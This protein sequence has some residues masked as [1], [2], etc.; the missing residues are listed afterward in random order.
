M[1]DAQNAIFFRKRYEFPRAHFLQYSDTVQIKDGDVSVAFVQVRNPLSPATKQCCFAFTS[2]SKPAALL[3]YAIPFLMSKMFEPQTTKVPVPI[4]DFPPEAG[5][6]VL[7]VEER[8]NARAIALA[9]SLRWRCNAHGTAQVFQD[10]E[11]APFEWSL[12]GKR[13]FPVCGKFSIEPL[14]WHFEYLDFIVDPEEGE[15]ESLPA[16]PLA[17][18][19]LME[20]QQL[21]HDNPRSALVIAVAAAEVGTK[22]CLKFIDSGLADI[23][24]ARNS[25]PIVDLLDRYYPKD[26]R[27]GIVPTILEQL[28]KAVLDR[29]NLVHAGKFTLRRDQLRRRLRAIEDLLRILDIQMGFEWAEKFISEKTRAEMG[30]PKLDLP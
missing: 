17:F 26:S 24:D 13:W 27:M 7:A 9:K 14:E 19:L 29:N 11:I 5:R 28:R 23:L 6:A 16:E 30:L 2:V 20:A 1:A 3:T 21:Q 8:L 4:K 15:Y 18:E 12:D 22:V 10:L 25:P